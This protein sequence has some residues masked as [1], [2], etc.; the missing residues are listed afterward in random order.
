MRRT[1]RPINGTRAGGNTLRDLQGVEPPAP[2]GEEF[3]DAATKTHINDTPAYYYSYAFATVLKFQLHDYI[4]RKI[5]KQPPQS[6]NYADNKEVGA[7]LEED[8]G[9]RRHRG[10]AQGFEGCDRRRNFDPGDGG[11]FQAAAIVARRAKQRTQIGWDLGDVER[12]PFRA[13]P[14]CYR[15]RH[16]LPRAASRRFAGKEVTGETSIRRS[17]QHRKHS[18]EIHNWSRE[19]YR[20]RVWQ[21]I[22]AAQPNA[23][24]ESV[25]NLAQRSRDF[26]L[27]TQNVDDLHTR[28]CVDGARL[29]EEQI[30]D[31]GDIFITRCSKCDFAFRKTEQ[32]RRGSEMRAL[33]CT[34]AP[35]SYLVW[36]TARSAS[37]HARGKFPGRRIL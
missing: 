31:T 17:W 30:V 25:V 6:C 35:G 24:R 3:C 29:S 28:A 8:H 19:W 26:L 4:A 36:R 5:L 34:D 11:I 37:N 14:G 7:W 10:L 15:R 20:E 13:C 18:R 12:H 21:R 2:R 27:V 22:R 16:F 32:D 1:C 33:Q 23:A 9:E